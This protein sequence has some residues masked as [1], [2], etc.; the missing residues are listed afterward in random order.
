VALPLIWHSP[1]MGEWAFQGSVTLVVRTVH[2]SFA[3]PW[4][5]AVVQETRACGTLLEQEASGA[6][7]VAT[8]AHSVEWVQSASVWVG[9]ELRP[10][11]SFFVSEWA[12]LAIGVVDLADARALPPSANAA[13]VLSAT[14]EAPVPSFK[15]RAAKRAREEEEKD[16]EF[17][18]ESVWVDSAR[19]L[20][21]LADP[22][23]PVPVDGF[24][25]EL[26]SIER[27]PDRPRAVYWMR[28]DG[29]GRSALGAA[30]VDA[31]TREL[32]GMVC[33]VIDGAVHAA[34][35]VSVRQACS[36]VVAHARGAKRVAHESAS[37][38]V[39]PLQLPFDPQVSWVAIDSD[40][41]AVLTGARTG[42]LVTASSREGV[43]PGDLLVSVD[44]EAVGCDG[45]TSGGIP[46]PVSLLSRASGA[47]RVA[48]ETIPTPFRQTEAGGA[49]SASLSVRWSLDKQRRVRTSFVLAGGF[50]I[51]PLHRELLRELFGSGW[52]KAAPPELVTRAKATFLGSAPT[53]LVCVAVEDRSFCGVV[54]SCWD[55]SSR[56]VP[57]ALSELESLLN[58]AKTLLL[59]LEGPA[60]I[61][62]VSSTSDAAC[63]ALTGIGAQHSLFEVASAAQLQ[64]TG[65]TLLRPA[66]SVLDLLSRAWK[67]RSR[68]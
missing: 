21:V 45:L 29:L 57:K 62:Q 26:S 65:R 12:E 61:L 35:S 27:F 39:F 63:R 23:S 5:D 58:R 37:F 53:T 46:W 59:L 42:V 10:V 30:V 15:G 18:P 13:M 56:V 52:A 60:R 25:S 64:S 7:V 48:M 16:D 43:Q 66:P 17:V 1:A 38:Q 6:L 40:A 22:S 4:T 54:Q 55:G 68:K 28:C 9:G 24:K 34:P 36:A 20:H 32:V 41:C 50:A 31:E 47:P 51:V 11:S 67:G 44:G 19:V 14:A 2:P 49:D 33:Q 8:S 3:C